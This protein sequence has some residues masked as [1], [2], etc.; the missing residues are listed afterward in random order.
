VATAILEDKNGAAIC[1]TAI[2]SSNSWLS[3]YD[4]QDNYR[5]HHCSDI[6]IIFQ[7]LGRRRDNFLKPESTRRTGIG[8]SILVF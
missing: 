7:K 8:W 5:K 1:G 3:G 6:E 4:Q 2:V